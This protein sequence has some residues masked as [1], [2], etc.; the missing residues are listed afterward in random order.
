MFYKRINKK[1]GI[2]KCN[3]VWNNK[4]NKWFYINFFPSD[5]YSKKGYYSKNKYV[6]PNKNINVKI[7]NENPYIKIFSNNTEGCT[8]KSMEQIHKFD[9][10]N[11]MDINTFGS[12]NTIL[13]SLIT[14]SNGKVSIRE[15]MKRSKYSKKKVMKY[16]LSYI[17]KP[18]ARIS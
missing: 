9:S 5:Y 13:Y 16:V 11:S 1:L 8:I 3:T 18:R 4:E 7:I 15:V 12:N 10:V 6:N 2:K 17:N 14:H